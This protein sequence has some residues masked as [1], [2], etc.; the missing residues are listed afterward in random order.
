LAADT[1]ET[2]LATE[3]ESLRRRQYELITGLLNVLP[4]VDQLGE[5]R[6]S[7]MRD[8]LFHADHPFLA[9]LVGPFNSG[10]SSIINAL[11]GAPDLL[12]VGPVPTTDRI[13]I[14]RYGEEIQR[15][16]T[17]AEV[18]TVFHPSPLLQR[19]SL[20]DTPGLESVFQRHEE[21][22]RRFLHRADMVLLVMLATQAMTARNLEYLQTLKEY[23]KK[24]IIVINQADLLNTA[25]TASVLEYVTQ[26]SQSRLGFKPEIWMV[27]AKM[28]LEA[29]QGG[30]RDV[31][32]WEASGLNH[33]ENW[34]E[35]QLGDV[36]RLRQK[37][38]TPLQIVSNVNQSALSTVRA[39]QSALDHYQSIAANLEQQLTSQKRDQERT[40]R[41][42]STEA[43]GHF[44]ESA[45]RGAAAI[46]ETFRLGN[47]LRSI[48]GGLLE[49]VGLT[50]LLRRGP[51]NSLV[52]QV[53]ERHRAFE[54]LDELAATVDKLGPRLEGKDLQDVDDLVKY[55][56]KEIDVLPGAISSKVIGSVQ[57]PLGYDRKALTEARKTLDDIELEARQDES[58]HMDD[59]LRNSRL[60]L[61]VWELLLVIFGAFLLLG[62]R[63]L[64][65]PESP[66]PFLVLIGLLLM[67]VGGLFAMPLR[68]R[69]LQSAHIARLN[70]LQARYTEALHKAADKQL[71]YAMRL[72]RDA[73]Q[74]LT[75]LIE[76]Q[77]QIHA[78]QL[79]ALQQASQE[80][81]SI[82]RD[83]AEMGK[84]R[85]MGVPLS[86]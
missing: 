71:D 42:I 78:D 32:T 26:E 65:P 85:L 82:E 60:Y 45:K 27:S 86:A 36:A 15:M 47:A 62:G 7:Q 54:P 12:T 49:L 19:V 76:S 6:L 59:L 29:W 38:T 5:E 63:N 14:L 13:N 33:F 30:K 8:A 48:G 53:F 41:E 21:I 50:G 46:D 20:V 2:K 84:R 35:Q 16:I 67:G 83:L 1:V 17:G 79:G 68:G 58:R 40:V 3:Y 31:A 9:V 81:V 72:R 74:P 37:L 11:L 70:A 64:W 22:T 77:T 24:V 44:T 28:G 25:E 39:N 80:I 56:R 43:A 61:A 52:K 10:K 18:E 57:P 4:K 55:A 66:T 69:M 73:V 34:I 75:R 23:G 51:A